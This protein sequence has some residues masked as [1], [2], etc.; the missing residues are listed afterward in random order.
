M[1]IVEKHD[2]DEIKWTFVK[3]II[4]GRSSHIACSMNGKII[5]VGGL[6]P[7]GIGVNSIKCYDPR[8]IF[9]QWLVVVM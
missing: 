9:R 5:V 6:N 8:T 4:A 1:H 3:S 2:A 7:F